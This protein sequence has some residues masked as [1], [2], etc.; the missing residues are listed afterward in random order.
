MVAKVY[1]YAN[2]REIIF[3]Y[4]GNETWECVIPKLGMGDY[5]VDLYAVDVAG[6]VSY[7]A[8]VLFIVDARHVITEFK[9]LQVSSTS[10]MQLI[11]SLGKMVSPTIKQE[12]SS[13]ICTPHIQDFK[14]EIVRCETCGG[15]MFELLDT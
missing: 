12:S 11:N 13:Y 1:G 10:S 5:V 8:T 14:M 4:V 9:I 3:S 7:T 15:D 6:N 2:G